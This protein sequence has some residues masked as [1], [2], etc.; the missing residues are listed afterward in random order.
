V[1][2]IFVMIMSMFLKRFWCNTMC[3]T[4]TLLSMLSRFVRPRG[5]RTD[6]TV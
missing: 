3:P 2:V 5:G 6:E 4:G 1:L